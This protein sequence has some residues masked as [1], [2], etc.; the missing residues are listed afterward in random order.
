MSIA[1]YV[2]KNTWHHKALIASSWNFPGFFNADLRLTWAKCYLSTTGCTVFKL[3]AQ[4]YYLLLIDSLQYNFSGPE[5]FNLVILG[6]NVL[7]LALHYLSV[8]LIMVWT[9]NSTVTWIILIVICVSET[10]L[11][12]QTLPLSYE[13]LFF[14]S[15]CMLK[16]HFN[17]KI[18][19]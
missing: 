16:F 6:V 11:T 5:F 2:T 13:Y 1:Q 18:S 17:I 8:P 3:G 19:L 15:S 12:L 10:F 9:R 14:Y 7:F 4:N